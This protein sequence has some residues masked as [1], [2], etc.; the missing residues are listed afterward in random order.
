MR[1]EQLD[2][3][4][5]LTGRGQIVDGMVYY[6]IP[7]PAFSLYGVYYDSNRIPRYAS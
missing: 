4:F 6:N 5:E 3:N 1:L 7:H 2:R